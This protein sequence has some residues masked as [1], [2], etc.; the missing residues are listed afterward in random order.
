MSTGEIIIRYISR[1]FPPVCLI[2]RVRNSHLPPTER[3]DVSPSAGGFNAPAPVN[4]LITPMH[5]PYRLYTHL[6]LLNEKK[7]K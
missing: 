4:T 7:I 6:K 1:C 3:G 5:G 2:I